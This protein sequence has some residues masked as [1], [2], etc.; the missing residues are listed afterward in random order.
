MA[1]SNYDFTHLRTGRSPGATNHF[2]SDDILAF[3]DSHS[4]RS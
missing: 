3:K 2:N 4:H 1:S